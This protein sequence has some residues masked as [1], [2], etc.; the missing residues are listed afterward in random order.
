MGMHRQIRVAHVLTSVRDGGLERIVLEVCRGLPKERYHSQVCAL[1]ADNPWA[2]AFS[3]EGIP[4][5]SWTAVNKP[6]PAALVPNAKAVLR[7]AAH[8]R[9]TRAEIVVVHDFFPGV[10]GRVAAMAARVP[11]RIG[12][13]HA[14]YDWLGPKAGFVNRLL[15]AKT[16]RL[17]AVSRA[18]AAASQARDRLPENL[19]EIIPN[20][21]DTLRFR[22]NHPR[23]TEIRAQLGFADG[24]IAIGSVGVIRES[25]RQIDLVQAFARFLA[26][27]PNAR[28]VLVGSERPHEHA[29]AAALK[30][31]IA[32][33]P[34]DRIVQVQNR[35]DMDAIYSAFDLFVA[36]SGSEGFGLAL[37]EAMAS[38]LPCIAS[39]IPPHLEIAG[40][41]GAVS[42][43][44]V[45][46]PNQLHRRILHLANDPAARGEFAVRGRA[47]IEQAFSMPSMLR[48][49]D[50]LL[51]R[52]ARPRP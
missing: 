32:R 39:D 31:E 30:A 33:L 51:T 17:V 19:Y 13:L 52:L 49:W 12:V 22:S 26:D 43:Y 38:G 27:A 45:G 11:C 40:D 10:L 16:D 50:A 34:Q 1:L 7:L 15:G 24:D 35:Q 18:A 5:E 36:P 41:D 23:R 48:Q 3:A 47:R 44:P 6:G 21:V 4:F 28:L 46:D 42:V 14:T 25:K 2:D 8:L 29:Y 20:G 37:A 9:R